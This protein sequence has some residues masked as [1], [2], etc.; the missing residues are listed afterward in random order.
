MSGMPVPVV[1]P[2]P[3]VIR[4][5]VVEPRPKKPN[6]WGLWI[7]LILVVAAILGGVFIW[8]RGR[9]ARPSQAQETSA[10]PAI[11]TA[12]VTSGPIEKTLRL[13]G[14]TAAANYTSLVT[15]NLR[16]SRGDRG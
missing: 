9:T 10:T 7:V 8:Q 15:P 4:P 1:A 11:R 3:P 2:P 12:K 14:V 16:G 6:H 5:E 13:T